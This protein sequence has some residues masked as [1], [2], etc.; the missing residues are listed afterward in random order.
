MRFE[1]I[2]YSAAIAIIFGMVYYRY[3]KREYP[4]IIIASA[5][6]PD[7]DIAA[8]SILRMLNITLLISGR[9]IQHG[10]FHNLAA[11]ILYAFL[12]S[13]LLKLISI[14]FMDAFVFSGIGFGAHIF[15]EMLISPL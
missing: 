8:D 15:E 2:I 6:A 13:M 5:Y 12:I 3:A 7:I 11:L 14:R 4:W 1:H 9:P 10:D